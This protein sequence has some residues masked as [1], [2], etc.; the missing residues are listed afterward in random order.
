MHVDEKKAVY[1]KN[2]GDKTIFFCSRTCLRTYEKPEV[3]LKNLKRLVT[4]SIIISLPT[5]YISFFSN[6]ILK[7]ID[8]FILATTVQFMAGFRFYR[9]TCDS[10]RARTPNMD[11]LIATGT[12]AAWTFS[13]IVTF[14]PSV[15]PGGE[16]YFDASVII[17]TLVLL[18]KLLE[19]I[20]KGRAS[21][22]IKKL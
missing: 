10:L 15:F 19:E 3:E 22:A 11:T 7:N 6:P 5:I 2:V 12:S 8:L 20:S 21:S 9:G 16:V 18:G 4:F 17:I 14:F 1:K 13:T